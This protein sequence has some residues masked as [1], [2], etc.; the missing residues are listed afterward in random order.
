[1]VN[2]PILVDLV[3]KEED[4]RKPNKHKIKSYLNKIKDF[5]YTDKLTGLRNKEFADLALKESINISTKT[6]QPFT[7]FMLD[8]AGLKIFN[9]KYSR[10]IGDLVIKTAAQFLEE[11]IREGDILFKFGD[12]ADEFGI[13]LKNTDEK[14]AKLFNERLIKNLE[15]Y[16]ISFQLR[17]INFKLPLKL[18]IGYSTYYTNL[19]IKE[20]ILKANEMM[21]ETKHLK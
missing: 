7:F 13:I 1:M 3:L 16:S 4:R 14:E 21:N 19:D 8:V 5:S 17:K 18:H 11:N 20:V 10:E 12:S 9:N 15:N 6:K 2:I